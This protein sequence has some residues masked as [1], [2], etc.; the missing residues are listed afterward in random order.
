LRIPVWFEEKIVVT[1]RA[2]SIEHLLFFIDRRCDTGGNGENP[3]NR[4]NEP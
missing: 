2:L 4:E 3:P 1:H